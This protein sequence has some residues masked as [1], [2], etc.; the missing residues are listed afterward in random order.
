MFDIE[1]SD[2]AARARIIVIITGFMIS[3]LLVSSRLLIVASS[4]YVNYKNYASRTNNFRLDITDRNG[5]LLAVNLPAASLYANPRKVV[6]LDDSIAKLL[7]VFPELDKEKLYTALKSNKSFVWI[8]R[9]ITPKEQEKIYNLGLPGFDFEREKKRIYTYGNLLAHVVG[10][11]GRDTQGLAGVE[12]YYD[13]VLTNKKITDPKIDKLQLSIDIR[14]QNILSNELDK[15]IKKFS[16]IGGAGVIVNPNNGEILALVSKPDFDPHYPGIAKA[17][18]LFNKATL[19]SYELGSAMK[20]LTVAVGLDT[21]VT[22]IRDAYD[23]SYMKVSGKYI[24]D[25]YPVKG[26][27]TVP[28]IFMKSSNIGTS[29]IMLEIGKANLKTYLKKLG[30]LDKLNLEVS[31]RSRP[32][33]PPYNRWTDLS[34]VTMSYGYGIAES[35]SH[36]IQAMIPIINGGMK[37]PLTL[38]K[39]A[40]GEKMVGERVFAEETSNNMRKLMHLGTVEGTSRK[41]AIKGYYIGAK[42][43][44]A[45]KLENGK[46]N[47]KNKRISSCF[48]ILPATK[49]EYIIYVMIDEPK[50]IKETYNFAGGGW[51]AAPVVNE[52]FAQMIAMY[53]ITKPDANSKE[54]KDLLDIEYKIR[55]ET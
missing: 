19:G 50:G 30:M 33:F 3:F 46:Y 20:T 2:V 39:R 40:D 37:Y 11:V 6:D 7:T 24:T 26:Y 42:T 4:E 9:D 34:L 45:E 27:K 38:I 55:D 21:G 47:K 8:K 1:T 5:N 22:T 10:Y 54:V 23:L 53:G 12:K 43:G 16:A 52:I 14:L 31:E 35:P 49:P 29:Q 25:T 51:V 28:Q 44:T 32:L 41:A 18:Q 17:E 15:A 36:F 13:E 48:A